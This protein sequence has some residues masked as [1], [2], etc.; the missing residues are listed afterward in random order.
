MAPLV[1][2]ANYLVWSCAFDGVSSDSSTFMHTAIQEF[3]FK[4]PQ[5]M[6]NN[7]LRLARGRIRTA[8]QTEPKNDMEMLSG[9]L[10]TILVGGFDARDAVNFLATVPRTLEQ[11]SQ[12]YLQNDLPIS[13]MNFRKLSTDREVRTAYSFLAQYFGGRAYRKDWLDDLSSLSYTDPVKVA[14]S[15][16]SS[17]APDTFRWR[18]TDIG[19]TFNSKSNQYKPY[20][21]PN[22]QA[23]TRFQKSKDENV[24]MILTHYLTNPGSE[25]EAKKWIPVLVHST[26]D[27][28]AKPLA[29]KL[30]EWLKSPAL[31]PDSGITMTGLRQKY[32]DIYGID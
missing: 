20:V 31:S 19:A 24:R 22:S 5:S 12:S 4:I 1:R 26:E 16:L 9:V 7:S 2:D 14:N 32:K 29:I 3:L 17:F 28:W 27:S 25:E 6:R 10:K 15:A 18:Y 8:S 13:A 30:A 11:D 23:L 21:E